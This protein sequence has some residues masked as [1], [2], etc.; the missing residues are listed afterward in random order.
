MWML[1]FL[2]VAWLP[3]P[4]AKSLALFLSQFGV[5]LFDVSSTT[6]LL[7]RILALTIFAPCGLS[8][9]V[10]EVRSS[11]ESMAKFA[12]AT[13]SLGVSLVGLFCTPSI[14]SIRICFFIIPSFASRALSL[15]SSGGLGGL[16]FLS[17]SVYVGPV[18]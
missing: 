11:I 14:P 5:S 2:R 7:L 16:A 10:S 6:P 18:W 9:S 12:L 4:L 3:V 13:I 1:L 15:L 8:A 17:T